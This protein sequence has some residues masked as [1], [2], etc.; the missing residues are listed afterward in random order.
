MEIHLSASD[1]IGVFEIL[2]AMSVGVK[3]DDIMTKR[4]GDRPMEDTLTLADYK[5]SNGA[6]FD[7]EVDTTD[8]NNS[9]L[10][11]FA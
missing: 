3:S 5:F 1:T 9:Q 4:Q 10:E 7:Y 2:A 8:F 6:S 11:S